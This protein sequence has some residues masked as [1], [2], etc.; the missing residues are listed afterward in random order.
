MTRVRTHALAVVVVAFLAVGCGDSDNDDQPSDTTA[1]ATSTMPD[2]A[3]DPMPMQV[4]ELVA[5]GAR[6][7]ALVSG[8]VLTDSTNTRLCELLMESFPAQCGGESVVIANP[9]VLTVDVDE[10]QGISWTPSPVLLSGSYDGD[11]L[12]V[13]G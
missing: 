4:D 10:T 6:A 5:G 2:D 9:E 13:N 7:E 12:V 1:M 11:E 3:G 8:F